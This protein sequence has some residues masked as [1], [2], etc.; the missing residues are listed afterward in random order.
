MS[1]TT[2]TTSD[3][4]VPAAGSVVYI[5]GTPRRVV[6]AYPRALSRSPHGADVAVRG[7]AERVPF[8]TYTLTAPAAVPAAAE[9][10]AAGD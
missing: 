3:Y 4:H 1:K 6:R 10:A 8:G 2:E 5:D 7:V 9:A